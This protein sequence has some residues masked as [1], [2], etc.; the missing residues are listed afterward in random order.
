MDEKIKNSPQRKCVSCGEMKDKKALLR[1]VKQPDGTIILDKTGKKNGR[2][3]YVC[4]NLECFNKAK[5]AKRFEKSFK[6]QIN[7]EIYLE[8]EKQI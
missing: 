6:C 7:A 4:S 5:K 3:A 2:G 1:V 8:L